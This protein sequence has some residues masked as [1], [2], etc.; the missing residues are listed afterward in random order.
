MRQIWS[1]SLPAL[2][3]L[4][5]AG[6]T[7]GG[8]IIRISG[9]ETTAHKS[10]QEALDSA[11]PGDVVE[12]SGGI[13]HENIR[14]P[15]SGT[16]DAPITLRGREGEKVIIDGAEPGL[17][18]SPKGRWKRVEED[19]T[20]Y[21]TT[22]LPLDSGLPGVNTWI[23]R[24]GFRGNHACD[25]LIASYATLQALKDAPRG[26]GSFRD[27]KQVY[28]RLERDED[29][30]QIGL[31]VGTAYAIVDLAGKSHIRLENLDLRNGGMV[32]IRLGGKESY[33]DIGIEDVVVRNC[34]TG[35][36]SEGEGDA[37]GKKVRIARA[38]VLN[39][40]PDSWEWH[41]GYIHGVGTYET[42]RYE[43]PW[44]GTGISLEN[45]E[46]SELYDSL[47]LGQW[48]GLKIRRNRVRVHHNT[49]GH[50]LDDGIELESPFS[51]NIEFYNNHIY[52]AWTGI[53]VTSNTPGPIYVYRNLVETTRIQRAMNPLAQSNGFSIKSGHDFAGKAENIKFYHNTFYANSY[54]VWEKTADP[55]PDR[56]KGYDFVNNIFFSHSPKANIV[57]RGES[58]SQSG[59]ENHWESNLY[60][61]DRPREPGALTET[62]LAGQFVRTF[63]AGR[64]LRLRPGTPGKGSGSDYPSA[65]SWPDSVTD[66]SGGRNRG[67][68][69]E[70]MEPYAIGAP[71]SVLEATLLEQ[72]RP[73][74]PPK[75]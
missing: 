5:F 16:P 3:A 33:E 11:E 12:L 35:I 66:F 14:F 34:W 54:N 29:P 69:E 15:K 26:E 30:N 43:G 55:E 2:L 38:R 65:Q 59:A 72:A 10:I 20:V 19:G 56:W 71:Q 1:F 52:D 58:E 41:G 68:W 28:V 7:F 21:F 57:F 6:P 74:A 32:G 53:S 36:Q 44:Q 31:S 60:N 9:E 63:S 4:C 23:S 75:R 61:I 8:E 25:K 50:I 37:I 17:Q 47:V 67:A 49:L 18:S 40:V 70:G 62:G 45:L 39:G 22:E 13:Y 46:D 73:P 24:H 42:A 48:D 27:A 51:A 64:D